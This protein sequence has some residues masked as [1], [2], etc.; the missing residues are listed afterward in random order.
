MKRAI[1]GI[2]LTAATLAWALIVPAIFIFATGGL[3]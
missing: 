3:K 2:A 1:V